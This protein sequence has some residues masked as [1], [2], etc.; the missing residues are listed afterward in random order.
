MIML[1]P[2]IMPDHFSI[3]FNNHIFYQ[4]YKKYKKN[5]PVKYLKITLSNT[6][7]IITPH[8]PMW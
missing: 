8:L 2:C 4:K 7:A 3:I 5:I 1:F 6:Y